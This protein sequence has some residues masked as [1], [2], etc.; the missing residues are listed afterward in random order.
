[1]L[2]FLWRSEEAVRAIVMIEITIRRLHS[3]LTALAYSL[4]LSG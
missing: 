1:M 2:M 3:R 4:I